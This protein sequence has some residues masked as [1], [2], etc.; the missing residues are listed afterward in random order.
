ML[1]TRRGD[2]GTSGLWG[3]KNRLPKDHPVFEVLGALDELNSLLG[4]CR[5]KAKG[6]KLSHAGPALRAV[7]ECL[8]IAQAEVAGAD[9]T[10]TKAHLDSL[11]AMI[12]KAERTV[13][14]PHA[15]VIPGTTERSAWFDYA[16]TVSRRVERRVIALKKPHAVAAG[17]RAYLNRLSSL[18]YA[19]ARAYAATSGAREPS[20]SYNGTKP[21]VL[22]KGRK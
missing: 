5:A 17:T 7:Q 18:L 2:D 8:F 4:L 15:F 6:G 1:Y 12:E 10:L 16:R 11:E 21:P 19:Y 14:N 3:T 20:P 22:K 13:K 9:K